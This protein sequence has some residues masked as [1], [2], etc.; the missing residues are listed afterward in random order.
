LG[1]PTQWYLSSPKSVIK[2]SSAKFQNAQ[3]SPPAYAVLWSDTTLTNSSSVPSYANG[4]QTGGCREASER[5]STRFELFFDLLF[6][7]I[8][9]QIAEAAA[10]EPTGIGLAKYILTFCPAYSV[11]ADVRDTA[12]QF[13]SDHDVTQRAYI[14]WIMIL[15][16]GYSNNASTIEWGQSNDGGQ[17]S[18]KSIDAQSTT[19]M[20]WTLGFYAAAKLSKGKFWPSIP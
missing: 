1:T 18:A 10:E 8:V 11:W 16:V 7:G 20:Q 14:L 3:E 6:V 13:G 5:Q 12:N 15:L 17:A 9:H 4:C 2:D 19:A